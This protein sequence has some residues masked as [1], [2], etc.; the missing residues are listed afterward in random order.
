[1]NRQDLKI[2]IVKSEFN[3]DII[4]RMLEGAKKAALKASLNFDQIDIF[5]VPGAFELPLIAKKLAKTN[6]YQAIVCLGA[7][8]QGETAHFDFVSMGVTMGITQAS[9]ETEVPILFG[10]L[11]CSRD[12]A[13][14][15]SEGDRNKG[16][17]TFKAALKMIDT[18]S[19]IELVSENLLH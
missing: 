14:I 5:T 18:C 19:E 15:R 2:A 17:H 16:Y 7:V 11:T 10:I 13:Y 12:Q 4:Q 9:L 6:Q 3:E 1:M 8:L